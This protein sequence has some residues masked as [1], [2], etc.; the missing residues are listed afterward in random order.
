MFIDMSVM[1]MVQVTVMEVIDVSV[2]FDGLVATAGS[3]Y[4]VV[5]IVDLTIG[6]GFHP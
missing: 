5:G 6:H 1:G 4:M 3:M 2:M